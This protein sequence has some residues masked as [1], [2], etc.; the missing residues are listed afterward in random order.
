MKRGGA[1]GCVEEHGCACLPQAR[2]ALL[3][4]LHWAAQLSASGATRVSTAAG[5]FRAVIFDV[6]FDHRDQP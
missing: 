3:S 1:A 4:S 6:K 2:A 5:L